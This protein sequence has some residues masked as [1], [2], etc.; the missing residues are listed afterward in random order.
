M[1]ICHNA[2]VEVKG[3]FRGVKSFFSP[4]F[5]SWDLTQV[6]RL[7]RQALLPAD[8]SHQL[9]ACL[10]K[11][12][13]NM[14]GVSPDTHPVHLLQLCEVLNICSLRGF[15]LTVFSALDDPIAVHLTPSFSSWTETLHYQSGRPLLILQYPSPHTPDPLYFFPF[16]FSFLVSPFC[17][18]PQCGVFKLQAAPMLKICT[19][20]LQL[21]PS[22]FF[23]CLILFKSPM[24]LMCPAH[25]CTP[26]VIQWVNMSA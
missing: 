11:I 25:G 3:Q 14:T 23:F 15:L 5:G 26:Y 18:S 6:T 12:E 21:H 4:L 7:V 2:L 8:L 13:W 24:E 20:E 16:C 17:F 10:I 19:T 9:P 1:C 22:F